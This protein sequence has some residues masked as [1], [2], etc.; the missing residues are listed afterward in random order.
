MLFGNPVRGRIGRPGHPDPVSRFV[1]TQP[2]KGA[3]VHDGLD[4]DNGGPVG[5]DPII[6]IRRGTVA[7]IREDSNGALIVRLN[8]ADG[9]SSGYGH[10]HEFRVTKVGQVV[11]RGEI[12]GL[13][14]DTGLHTGPHVHFDISRFDPKLGRVVRRDPWPLLEQNHP[15]KEDWMPL[16]LRE[17]FERCTVRKGTPFF[18]DGPGIGQRKVFSARAKLQTVAESADGKWRLLRYQDSASAP[19]ELL[20]VRTTQIRP[21]EPR[22][23]AYDK[24]CVEAI[25]AT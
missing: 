18:T 21:Q 19:R 25:L 24:S 8:H 1:V 16:P 10:L 23:A 13:L 17:R 3:S 20:Y 7:E 14:G 2:F 22:D 11:R 15:R 5:E 12:I 4:I 9:W 6:A